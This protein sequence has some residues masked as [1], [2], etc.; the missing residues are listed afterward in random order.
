MSEVKVKDELVENYKGYYD[1]EIAEWRELGA[2]DK[3][4]N[5][6]SLASKIKHDKILEIGCGDGS[7]LSVKKFFTCFILHIIIHAVTPPTPGSMK[8]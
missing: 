3:L 2:I 6:L 7:I 8:H 1:D 5:I 4:E